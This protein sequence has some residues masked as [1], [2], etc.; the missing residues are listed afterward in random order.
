MYRGIEIDYMEGSKWSEEECDTYFEVFPNTDEYIK[1]HEQELLNGH[2]PK[3]IPDLYIAGDILS[4]KFDPYL[5]DLCLAWCNLFEAMLMLEH[6]AGD[7]KELYKLLYHA[8]HNFNRFCDENRDKFFD[9]YITETAQDIMYRDA[10]WSL[11]LVLESTNPYYDNDIEYERPEEYDFFKLSSKKY[12]ALD[13]GAK[14]VD[15]IELTEEDLP[16]DE[17]AF[18]FDIWTKYFEGSAIENSQAD[19]GFTKSHFEDLRNCIIPEEYTEEYLCKVFLKEFGLDIDNRIVSIYETFRSMLLMQFMSNAEKE[20]LYSHLYL[21]TNDQYDF[22]I[23]DINEEYNE[24][25]KERRRRENE[26]NRFYN[27]FITDE[28]QD[29]LYTKA[30]N[31]V[32][33]IVAASGVDMTEYLKQTKRTKDYDFHTWLDIHHYVLYDFAVHYMPDGIIKEMLLERTC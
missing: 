33:Y 24:R 11:D 26:L 31:F 3:E 16:K 29:I 9:P 18:K 4:D 2:L 5:D 13:F 8:A 25:W 30:Y 21:L 15:H 7:K 10:C 22:Y 6:M 20:S 27:S 28:I 19:I 12:A 23:F 14:F 17:P 1:E 32:K